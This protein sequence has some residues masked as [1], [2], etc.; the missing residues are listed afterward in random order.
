SSE[1]YR[2]KAVGGQKRIYQVSSTGIKR[3][4]NYG[5]G[6]QPGDYTVTHL[7]NLPINIQQSVWVLAYKCVG[8]VKG[9]EYIFIK[10]HTLGNQLLQK[11]L[12]DFEEYCH[13]VKTERIFQEIFL[14]LGYIYHIQDIALDQLSLSSLVPFTKL[15]YFERDILDKLRLQ[16][17]ETNSF[18]YLELV[19]NH[20]LIEQRLAQRRIQHQTVE[21]LTWIDSFF[22]WADQNRVKL[23]AEKGLAISTKRSY[24]TS[25][26]YIAK[27]LYKSQSDS[28]VF[29]D[30]HLIQKL[31]EKRNQLKVSEKKQKQ[32][33]STRCLEWEEAVVIVE[34]QREKADFR[35]GVPHFKKHG[36][37]PVKRSSRSIASELQKI[38]I[39]FLMILIPSDRQQTY[40][41]LQ[42]RRSIRINEITDGV[43]LLWGD[44]RGEVFTP[45]DQMAN[46][47]QAQWWLAVY[48]FKTVER[49]G[50]FWYPLPNQQFRDGK[51][52]Y[53]YLE[54]WFFGLEDI[55]DKW[56]QYYKGDN[57]QWQGHIDEQGQRLGW[58]A[59]L[60]PNHD[61]AFSMR[62]TQTPH[63]KDSFCSLVKQIFIEFTPRLKNG[64]IVPVT[65]HSF[66]T[67]L[68][69][70]TAG[71]LTAA[72]EASM[73]YCEHHSIEKRRTSYT[74]FNNMRQITEA[75]KVMDRINQSLFIT[76]ELVPK[77]IQEAKGALQNLLQG[78]KPSSILE[79]IDIYGSSCDKNRLSMLRTAVERYGV[80]GLGGPKPRKG[81]KTTNE[82][83]DFLKTIPLQRLNNL[84]SAVEEGCKKLKVDVRGISKNRS[85]V[86]KF[87]EFCE[88]QK[89]LECPKHTATYMQE[90]KNCRAFNK[91]V[92][93]TEEKISGIS[94]KTVNNNHVSLGIFESDFI[95]VNGAKI[96]ANQD[97]C[98]ELDSFENYVIHLGGA[99]KV[100]WRVKHILGFLHRIQGTPLSDLR[101]TSLVPFV[102]L[103]FNESNTISS[104][105][106]L[107]NQQETTFSSEELERGIITLEGL[108]QQQIQKKSEDLINL[109][110]SYFDW[111]DQT[112][113]SE[114]GLAK[115]TKLLRLNSFINV[116]KFLYHNE[117]LRSDF[118]DI[119]IINKLK[120]KRSEF[121]HDKRKRQARV[122]ARCI[123]WEETIQVIEMQ[124]KQADLRHNVEIVSKEPEKLY[125]R[126]KKLTAIA[127]NLEK[128]LIL[129]MLALIPSDRQQTYRRLQFRRSI[130]INETIDGIF[131]LWGDF[132]GELFTPRDQM[133]NPS[134]AQW[135][136]AVYD[137]KT[138]ERFGPFWY[139]LPNQHFCDGKT[140]YEYL[141]MWFFG[142]E[143]EAGKWPQYYRGD[144][145]QWQGHIDEQGQRLG[146]RAALKPNHDF[147]F[148]GLYSGKA[149]EQLDFTQLVENIFIKFTPH[150]DR[151]EVVPVTPNSFRTMLTTYTADKLTPA[152]EESMAY[153]EH[154]SV[155]T[156]RE[157]Y[158]VSDNMRQIAEAIK[159]MNRINN[160][161]FLS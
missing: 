132:R 90:V 71:R 97:L 1:F 133:A 123:T 53:E 21:L 49:F 30:I 18:K 77:R 150:L 55:A 109:L 160:S 40:R 57:A 99:Q 83:K 46:P 127:R 86:R 92:I 126:P 73:A 125:L 104:L 144:N 80:I 29:K 158:V 93:P 117:T 43:F 154:H 146:W 142:L 76:D 107:F 159:V 61:F 34:M 79:A 37:Y 113:V 13:P 64:E 67:M 147:V 56:P 22:S 115:G 10:Y 87:L 75:I 119:F 20:L 54:M 28:K 39:L 33:I 7:T 103:N 128:T 111:L 106:I 110:D 135:W 62:R 51:T 58:R 23:G 17:S 134:Q 148:C 105:K 16:D 102:Q 101:L 89:W 74:L 47:S 9:V 5:L 118:S 136:L 130:R 85:Y 31:K 15:K 66:R 45:R 121:I 14:M 2:F 36:I 59:A 120:E 52:F 152:E 161:L 26:I 48:D 112:T 88:K 95:E 19:Q 156:R 131:L 8:Y 44:F 81:K 69:T 100:I 153:C 94:P 3:S 129:L 72:E 27:F 78:S 35:H 42:F 157:H 145:A 141:E 4:A 139:P 96:L 38:I 68:A 63:D 70:Y 84:L 98:N 12:Q 60:E 155:A 6:T 41:R 91:K 138:A 108:A 50:P 143:D 82:S 137:F 149:L 24:I 11:E 114:E 140:F 151:A 32:Q 122:A 124:R 65:P 116:A 25:L